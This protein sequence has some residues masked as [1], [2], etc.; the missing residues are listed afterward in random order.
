MPDPAIVTQHSPEVSRTIPQET[1]KSSLHPDV[2]APPAKGGFPLTLST[3]TPGTV[4]TSRLSQTSSPSLD[5]SAEA[6]RVVGPRLG[7]IASSA[8]PSTLNA[9]PPVDLATSSPSTNTFN[10]PPGSRV[11]ALKSRVSSG[12]SA[13]PPGINSLPPPGL[14]AP[15]AHSLPSGVSAVPSHLPEALSNDMPFGAPRM[16]PT[17]P[18]RGIR[19]FSP[20]GNGSQPNGPLED[21]RESLHIGQMNEGIRRA[22]G[23]AAA[24]ERAILG[25][26]GEAGSPYGDLGGMQPGAFPPGIPMDPSGSGI[27]VGAN[28]AASKG[29]RFAKFFDNKTREVQA[30]PRLGQPV[31]GMSPAMSHPNQRQESMSLG[32]MT[33]STLR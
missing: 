8:P 22:S 28:Y 20:L 12:S 23:S 26:A 2:N 21:M 15:P 18:S 10:P 19:S 11:L 9:L 25:L 3:T 4:D 1:T 31:P 27:P 5:R 14:T 7:Q 17:D 16:T 24:A 30:G 33:T 13:A 6:S 32:G 29:S